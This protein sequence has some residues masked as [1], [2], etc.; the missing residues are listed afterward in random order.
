M[1]SWYRIDPKHAGG[2]DCWAAPLTA[3]CP[4]PGHR[5][6]RSVSLALRPLWPP[7]AQQAHPPESPAPR[8]AAPPLGAAAP[9]RPV[10]PP[11][12]QGPRLQ[13]EQGIRQVGPVVEEVRPVAAATRCRE[14]GDASAVVLSAVRPG[15]H[16]PP[17]G[18]P[19]GQHTRLRRRSPQLPAARLHPWT[20]HIQHS[21]KASGDAGD[22]CSRVHGL[23]LPAA[24][25]HTPRRN[26]PR[27][28]RTRNTAVTW[29]GRGCGY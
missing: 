26:A 12:P 29:S 14:V 19:G 13:V 27:L 25:P 7:S 15:G 4:R 23:P 9:P 20:P 24:T 8:P 21:K 1:P 6:V 11:Q 3:A 16:L 18:P 17:G 22:V 2:R 5:L 28:A 10:R